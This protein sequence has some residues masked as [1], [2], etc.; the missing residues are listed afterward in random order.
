MKPFPTPGLISGSHGD[1]RWLMDRRRYIGHLVRLCPESFVGRYLCVTAIDSGPPFLNDS[2]R[3]AGWEIRSGIAYSQK[4]S[5]AYELFYQRDGPDRAGFD[6]WYLFDKPQDLGT[7]CDGNPFAEE[8]KPRSGQVIRFVGFDFSLDD[9]D[10]FI[11]NLFWEQV[12]RIRPEVYVCDGERHLTFVSRKEALFDIVDRRLRRDNV[13][14][15][16]KG[17]RRRGFMADL[18]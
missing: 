18:E 11:A 6:E 3:R 8:N 10:P 15:I 7:L 5:D 2:Q 9:A 12:D 4:V 1:Y 16:K 13:E 17:D 14:R